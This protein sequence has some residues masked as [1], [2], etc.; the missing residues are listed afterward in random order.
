VAEGSGA[1]LFIV[2]RGEVST[3]AVH[4]GILRGVTRDAVIELARAAKLPVHETVLN[5]FDLYTADEVFYTG[6]G[7]EVIHARTIDGRQIG[8]GL[9]G[10][11][12]QSL[13]EGFRKLVRA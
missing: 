11:V 9:A 12:T 4:S 5:R 8:D 2:R 1:N 13:R 6:T 3:P 7:A 10:K